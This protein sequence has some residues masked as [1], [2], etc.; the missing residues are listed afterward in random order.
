[1]AFIDKAG[2]ILKKSLTQTLE[3]PEKLKRGLEL[4]ARGVTLPDADDSTGDLSE[5]AFALGRFRQE[6]RKRDQEDIAAANKAKQEAETRQKL[7]ELEFKKGE[8]D[9]KITA[10]VELARIGERGD[11]RRFKLQGLRLAK[12]D[13][14][15]ERRHREGQANAE[16]RLRERMALQK[17]TSARSR[18]T[19]AK[20][21][22]RDWITKNSMPFEF[23][24]EELKDGLLS[25]NSMGMEIY[26]ESEM[27]LSPQ[28]LKKLI[29]SAFEAK[30]LYITN[31]K[32]KVLKASQ[33]GI[34]DWSDAT[35]S[36]LNKAVPSDQQ[37][38]TIKSDKF[39]PD[40]KLDGKPEDRV[41]ATQSRA[42]GAS[43]EYLDSFSRL[44]PRVFLA[45]PT[46]ER[47]DTLGMRHSDLIKA[48]LRYSDVIESALTGGLK[49][50][51]KP[52]DAFVKQ[53]VVPFLRKT[54][55]VEM[56]EAAFNRATQPVQVE[57]DE[58]LK[59]SGRYTVNARKFSFLS[60]SPIV[61][62]TALALKII[63]PDQFQ[64]ILASMENDTQENAEFELTPINPDPTTVRQDS[65]REKNVPPKTTV[66]LK[67]GNNFYPSEAIGFMAEMNNIYMAIGKENK[68]EAQ[69]EE[70]LEAVRK[71]YHKMTPL[72]RE[73]VY[74]TF[75]DILEDNKSIYSGTDQSI[76]EY[77]AF[78][79]T[80]L[81]GNVVKKIVYKDGQEITY[82]LSKDTQVNKFV[83]DSNGN[84]VISKVFERRGRVQSQ[85]L[86]MDIK[87]KGMQDLLEMTDTE[88]NNFLGEASI[89]DL[90][91][92]AESAELAGVA[93]EVFLLFDNLIRTSKSLI[94]GIPSEIF[95]PKLSSRL[96]TFTTEKYSNLKNNSMYMQS[97]GQDFNQKYGYSVNMNQTNRD[98]MDLLDAEVNDQY[99]ALSRQF[100]KD[101]GQGKTEAEKRKAKATYLRRT[102]MLWEKTALTYQLAGYVQGDQTGGRTISNQ[103]FDNIYRALWGGKF[104]TEEGAR[105]A[106]RYLMYK[107]NE[108]LA[109]GAAEDI[110][111]QATGRTFAGSRRNIAAVRYVNRRRAASYFKDNPSVKNYLDSTKLGGDSSDAT[112]AKRY[113]DKITTGILRVPQDSV[114]NDVEKI[115][116]NFI[117]ENK[118]KL[119]D[120]VLRAS[121][122][123]DDLQN[124]KLSV[125]SDGPEVDK[126][127]NSSALNAYTVLY[128]SLKNQDDF[129][130]FLVAN[131]LF[132][133]SSD[134]KGNPLKFGGYPQVLQ[135]LSRLTLDIN[136]II[137]KKTSIKKLENM[138]S[139][140]FNY[141]ELLR[142]QQQLNRT[143]Q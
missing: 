91:K 55:G 5:S 125:E 88:A 63:E 33:D 96:S 98:R 14:A 3:D 111:L 74:E 100:L 29:T 6:A 79:M 48:N 34:T 142:R 61:A 24:G 45:T 134:A 118:G 31:E 80:E 2:E 20:K 109:R 21:A 26:K 95:S 133:N 97:R 71:D 121:R 108:A 36:A 60:S 138:K 131:S 75:M 107:N 115:R 58:S 8:L 102:T 18:K 83:K 116:N 114:N 12:S 101:S 10:D 69:I 132:V 40:T 137:G 42:E 9:R 22:F 25:L 11:E 90:R 140:N 124:Y 27:N 86:E 82:D 130:R 76:N 30:N 4:F 87:L 65:S 43:S 68:S 99:K 84:N 49:Q 141:L 77:D 23:Y 106:I 127:D 66:K 73:N 119:T 44:V 112:T 35:I 143:Q 54:K 64:S 56:F 94:T 38:S 19:E 67:A 51:N 85:R 110:L 39:F 37:V 52:L 70:M 81:L 16:R 128:N 46:K 28:A 41:N 7:A 123:Q 103:D 47:A 57:G 13:A 15:A 139:L 59:P 17:L 62:R 92:N 1:M 78:V 93:S 136:D 105:N 50:T 113:A 104:F 122:L 129:G 89:E 53:Y 72:Q 32:N 126:R 120:F 135:D 117:V